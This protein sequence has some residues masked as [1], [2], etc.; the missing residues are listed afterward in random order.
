MLAN[1]HTHTTF[2]DGKNT[3][4]EIVLYAIDRK[5]DS[6]G[7]SGHGYTP[8]DLRYCMKDVVGYMAEINRLKEKYKDKIQIYLGTE[9]DMFAP[10]SNRNEYDYI[11]GS[12]HYICADGKY[13]PI[14]S[15]VD[16]FRECLKAFND[17]AVKMAEDYY[18]HFCDYIVAR[19]PDIVGHF[20]LL[21]K[22]DEVDVPGFNGLMCNKEYVKIAE[23]AMEKI[24]IAD[25]VIEVNTGA[26]SR[27]YR[28]SPYPQQ[29]LL[30]IIR[31]HNGKLILS[32]DSHSVDTLD[33][34]FEESKKILIDAGFEYVYVLHDNTMKKDYIK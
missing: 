6:L 20:D 34:Y 25:V 26:I 32:S 24:M 4:E 21:T 14:D 30:H 10:V 29:D 17:D 5:F 12:C 31:K 8:Y 27:G 1:F 33:Y 16:Y 9:E 3:P 19:K 23:K 22:F 13:Y 7:F 28:T 2:C 18:G 15:G 11:L